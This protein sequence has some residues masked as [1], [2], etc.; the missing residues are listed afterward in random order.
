MPVS[1]SVPVIRSPWLLR[2]LNADSIFSLPMTNS[3]SPS[4]SFST[5]LRRASTV[6]RY[7]LTRSSCPS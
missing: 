5:G 4:C 1:G 7:C 2:P 6:R 3:G